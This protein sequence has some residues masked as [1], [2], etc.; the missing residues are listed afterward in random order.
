MAQHS[1]LLIYLLC[2]VLAPTIPFLCDAGNDNGDHKLYIVYMGSLPD[3]RDSS[4]YNSPTS[5]HL[6]MLQQ[7]VGGSDVTKHHVISYNRSFNGF[8]AKLSEKQKENIVAMDGVVSVFPSKTLQIQTTRSWDFLGLRESVKRQTKEESDL[9]IGVID[10][11]IWPEL[12]SFSDQG[13][14][15]I[16]AKWKGHCKGGANFTCNN[17][18]IGARAYSSPPNVTATN[19]NTVRDIE[20]HGSH[21][22][23]TAAGNTVIGASFYGLAQGTARGAVPSARIAAYKVCYPNHGCDDANILAAFDDAIADGVNILSVSLGT[24]YCVDL[25]S[26]TVAIGS[27][28]AM[29]RG[30]LTLQAAGNSGPASPSICSVAPWLLTVAASTIDRQFIDKVL[31]GNGMTLIGRSVNAVVSNGT[32]FPIAKWNA[33]DERCKGFSDLCQCLGS[34][35]VKGKVVLCEGRM[36]DEAAY[37]DGAV[38]SITE[39]LTNPDNDVSF[40]T[41]FPSVNLNPKDYAIVQNYTNSA[42]NP[43]AEILKSEIFKDRSAPKVVSFS[44]R[45]PNPLIPEIMKPD[46]SAPGVDILAA[47]SPEAAP[48]EY[49]SDKRKVR[50]NVVS[51]TSMAC[52]HV[53]GVAA[54]VKSFHPDW[55]PATIK[56]AIMTTSDPLNGNYN[57]IGEFSYGAGNVNPVKAIDPG[58]VYDISKKDYVKMLCNYGYSA[59]KVKIVAGDHSASCHGVA[60][61]RSLVKDLNYPAITVNVE[62]LKPYI[63]KVKR[64]VMNVGFPPNSTYKATISPNPKMNITVEPEVLRFKSL[65]EKHSFVVTV[66]GGGLQ[67][68]SAI[69]SSLVWSDGKHNVKSPIIV[70]VS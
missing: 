47:W 36:H 65:H 15:P 57:M 66:A 23:S 33:S 32:K 64:I 10:T 3:E 18:I 43:K 63:I 45:G 50:Y 68:D 34:E 21:T 13:V 38:G 20:G 25:L 70:L 59:K 1:F 55:S 67:R 48:S 35:S 11:G 53:A 69:S 24:N 8:A 29:E 52:P 19:D 58:L 44:S 12:D 9:V 62:P 39:D 42:K 41:Y 37:L 51:G 40:V 30:I 31:L 46:V 56:S 16:P 6:S 4:N 28:H 17:K 14:G 26:D 60:H 54:Y 49:S 5:H 7:V 22:A 2:F 61:N 27:F